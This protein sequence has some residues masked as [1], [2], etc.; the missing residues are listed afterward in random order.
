MRDCRVSVI[1]PA[2]NGERFI[3]EALDSIR[4]QQH[5]ALEIIVVDDGSTDGTAEILAGAADVNCIRQDNRG[6]ASARNRGIEIA[7]GDVIAFLDADDLWTARKFPRQLECLLAD[8]SADVVRGRTQ[9]I[10]EVRDGAHAPRWEPAGEAWDALSL[11]SSIVRRTAF[12]RV[13][14]FDPKLA[15]NEDVDWF[16]RAKEIGLRM[17]V[18]DDVVQLYRRHEHNIT[19]DSSTNKSYFLKALKNSIDRRRQTGRRP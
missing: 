11:G 7:T 18:H 15:R 4:R 9:R 17:I 2:Y 12:A 10:V 1:M 8:P 19:N 6:A 5:R 14:P 13:G 16:I 3:V